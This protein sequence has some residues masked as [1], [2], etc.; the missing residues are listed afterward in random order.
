MKRSILFGLAGFGLASMLFA[1]VAFVGAE[2][3]ENKVLLYM[4][5]LDSA[6]IKNGY[7]RGIIIAYP[8]GK[9]EK[10]EMNVNDVTNL[11]LDKLMPNTSLIN[12]ALN[13]IQSEGYSLIS[14]S[15]T[16]GM[17]TFYE[18]FVFEK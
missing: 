18:T 13:K 6:D 14:H 8:D 12:K 1:L 5:V 9:T 2:H 7:S 10:I 15:S 17:G 4:R 11:Q 16:N 3:N